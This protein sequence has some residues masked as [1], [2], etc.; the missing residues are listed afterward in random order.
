[1]ITQSNSDNQARYAL[2]IHRASPP[3]STHH[4]PPLEVVSST[5][6]SARAY[7][8]ALPDALATYAKP[9]GLLGTSQASVLRRL[10]GWNATQAIMW[11]LAAALVVG[12]SGA[13]VGEG[14]G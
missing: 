7:P 11:G 3:H 9:A 1:M 8:L 4:R 2:E 14:G 6:G 5:P 13:G 10:N 12:A